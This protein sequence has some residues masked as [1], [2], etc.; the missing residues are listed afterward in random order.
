MKNLFIFGQDAAAKRSLFA[1][2]NTHTVNSV[3]TPRLSFSFKKTGYGL[4][5]AG[6][7]LFEELHDE[8]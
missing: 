7:N 1:M 5:V 4:T 2:T 6:H 8:L 3:M